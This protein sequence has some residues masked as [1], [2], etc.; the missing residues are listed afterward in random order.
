LTG[1]SQSDDKK[2]AA[3]AGFDE[4]LTKPVDPDVLARVLSR[5]RSAA[6]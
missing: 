6:A 1:W 2:R 3:D 5:R 4:H